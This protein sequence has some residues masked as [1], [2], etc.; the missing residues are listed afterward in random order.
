MGIFYKFL[1]VF[2]FFGGGPLGYRNNSQLNS[3]GI[4]SQIFLMVWSS[5]LIRLYRILHA[6][7]TNLVKCYGISSQVLGVICSFL[8][9][10]QFHVVVGGTFLQQWLINSEISHDSILGF[11]IFYYI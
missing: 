7:L 11:T 9:G 6:D 3:Y 4:I 10:K 5:F 8:R 1:R 2:F